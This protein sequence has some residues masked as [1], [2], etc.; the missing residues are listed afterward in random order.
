MKKFEV[1]LV[2]VASVN[3]MVEA[4]DREAAIDLAFED[5]PHAAWNWPDMGEWTLGS[6]LFPKSH[7]ADDDVREV[8]S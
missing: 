2:A 1:S 7:S 4:E 5:A 3:V 6:E 8:T